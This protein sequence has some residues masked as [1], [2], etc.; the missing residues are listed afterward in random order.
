MRVQYSSH[1]SHPP[2]RS[3]P[4]VT[5]T[6][7]VCEVWRV[8]WCH[9]VG[10]GAGAS[11]KGALWRGGRP[12]SR[13]RWRPRGPSSPRDLWISRAW[14][15]A[16]RRTCSHYNPINTHIPHTS[17]LTLTYKF[18]SYKCLCFGAQ[19]NM[20]ISRAIRI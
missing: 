20:R 6:S 8:K 3:V 19:K 7:H 2:S 13:L 9:D 4:P 5:C 1:F 12:G 10:V 18:A 16:W 11:G 15:R 14:T 17:I